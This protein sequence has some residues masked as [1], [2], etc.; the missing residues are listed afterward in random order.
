MEILKVENLCLRLG[1]KYILHNLNMDLRKGHIHALVGP[2]GA[3]K[4][5][6]AFTVMGVEGYRN[7][8]GKINFEGKDITSLKIDE[9]ARY[10]I[11]LA[12]QEP[13]RYEGL[14]VRD[15]IRVSASDKNI[16]KIE[17]VLERMDMPPDEYLNRAVDK[18]LSGGERKKIELVSILAM[19]VK[20]IN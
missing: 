9:R 12:W 13:A 7:S 2:N 3:G 20:W 19:D 18:T 6:F 10:G 8:E 5:T 15:F 4:S 16:E 14:T 17:E 1:E 11:T